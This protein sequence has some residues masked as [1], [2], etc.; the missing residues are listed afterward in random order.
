MKVW[1]EVLFPSS[2]ERSNPFFLFVALWIASLALA[3]MSGLADGKITNFVSSP[4]LKNISSSHRTQITGVFLP[5][6]P[7]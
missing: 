3:M 6:R 2:R 1:L 7:T 5:S 4:F